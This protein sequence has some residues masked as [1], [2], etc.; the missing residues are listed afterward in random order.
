MSTLQNKVALVTGA[1]SGIGRATAYEFAKVGGRVAVVDWNEEQGEAT[2][3]AIRHQGQEAHFIYADV[4]KA[5]DV[6]NMEHGKAFR[7]SRLC[8]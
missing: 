7:S 4:S 2:A 3:A 1:A 8:L 6:E 5:A